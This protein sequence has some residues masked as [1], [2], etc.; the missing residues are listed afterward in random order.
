MKVLILGG[1]GVISRAITDR[2][3]AEGHGVTHFNR[4]TKSLPFAKSVRVLAGDRSKPGELE[5]ALESENFDAVIDMICFN[6]KDAEET[7]RVFRGR[8]QQLVITSSVAAYRRPYRSLPIRED[9]EELFTDS[10]FGYAFHKAELERFL[11]ELI[12]RE[13]L[14]VTIIR[15]S[16]TFGAGAANI[17]ILRQNYG[18]ID[19]MRKGKALV[20]FGDGSTP[21]SFTFAEDLAKAYAAVLGNPRTYGQAFHATSGEIC[22]WEDLYL[23]FGRLAGAEPKIIHISSEILMKAA[24]N[25]CAHLYHEKT[26]PGIFDTTKL[27]SAAPGFKPAITLRE[28]C[29]MLFAWWEKEAHAVD[30]EKDKLEDEL[31]AAYEKFTAS[32][33]GLYAK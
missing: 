3:L 21:W 12:G 15:P 25:L 27:R 7:V 5:R 14:P 11:W 17:G 30:P 29:A 13:K 28:G 9:S 4:G 20:M 6:R 32:I 33:S 22:R 16:L 10:S 1:T 31:A 24:P 2:L 18:I 8:T 26:Y 19:R 23:E